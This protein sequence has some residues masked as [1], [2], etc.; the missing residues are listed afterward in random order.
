MN[1]EEYDFDD[2]VIISAL[3][4]NDIDYLHLRIDVNAPIHE[5]V[6]LNKNDVIAMAKHFKLTADDLIKESCFSCSK[7][8]VP[9]DNNDREEGWFCNECLV[10]KG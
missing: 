1:I 5:I 4:S 7:D 8:F 6:E 10:N 3:I 2:N 9:D